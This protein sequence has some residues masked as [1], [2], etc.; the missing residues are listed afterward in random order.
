MRIKNN[1]GIYKIVN[2]VNGK[3]YVGSASCLKGRRVAHWG[4][5][6][7]GNHHS[8]KLQRAWEKYGPE[9]FEFVVIELVSDKAELIAREQ[10]WIDAL[11]AATDGYNICAVA[12]RT[13]GMYWTEERKRQASE[14]MRGVP[15]SEP[16]KA[17]MALSQTGKK[18]SEETKAKISAA[19]KIAFA[20]PEARAKISAANS[21]RKPS[22]EVRRKMSE[23]Q[24]AIWTDERRAEVSARM[25]SRRHSPEAKAKIALA[26][27]RR[28]ATPE[29]RARMSAAIL[30]SN[31]RKRELM[32]GGAGGDSEKPAC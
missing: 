20:N 10:H 24:R 19:N 18:L 13:E 31:Q 7:K 25:S 12:G 8:I 5:L 22:D 16:H 1:H 4:R 32:Q 30:E 11:G 21:G 14:R 26:N 9:A 3:V 27:S 23:A 28:V 2:S 17:M 15:K 29:S 6:R